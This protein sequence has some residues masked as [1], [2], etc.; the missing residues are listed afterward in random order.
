MSFIFNFSC[1]LLLIL[2][3]ACGG[4]KGAQGN[5]DLMQLEIAHY[6]VPCSGE[7]VQLC[8]LVKKDDGE[9][10]FFYEDIKGFNYK[11]G[12]NY[13]LSVERIK[14]ENPQADASAYEYELKKILSEEAVSSDTQF[15]LPVSLDGYPLISN[16]DGNCSYLSG[17]TIATGNTTCESLSSGTRAIFQHTASGLK[18]IELK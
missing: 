12:Y 3:S 10:A 17:K 2:L 1:S 18:L 7:G 14:L 16:K 13:S 4:T 11:W 9:Q 5:G 6:K 8:F 15:E